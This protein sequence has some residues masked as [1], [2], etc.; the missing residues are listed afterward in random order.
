[1]A[2]LIRSTIVD[3]IQA[4]NG[5]VQVEPDSLGNAATCGFLQQQVIRSDCQGLL[6]LATLRRSQKATTILW[7]ASAY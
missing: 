3:P 5:L 4:H 7:G 2:F 1:M 6:V